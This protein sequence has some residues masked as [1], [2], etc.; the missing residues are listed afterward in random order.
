MTAAT[1]DWK[2]ISK[3]SKEKYSLYLCSREWGVLKEAVRERSGGICERCHCNPMQACHHL[4]YENKYEEK[5]EDLQAICQECHDFTHG[6]SDNDPAALSHPGKAF[7][8]YALEAM[9]AGFWPVPPA[10]AMRNLEEL[11]PVV[12]LVFSELTSL[13]RREHNDRHQIECMGEKVPSSLE[14]HW[15]EKRQSIEFIQRMCLRCDVIG[16]IEHGCPFVDW[17]EYAR[18]VHEELNVPVPRDVDGYWARKD[19]EGA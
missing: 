6:K 17:H 3:D 12:Q 2:S 15:D 16:Y 1:R 8:K 13:D 19:C 5:L 14:S 10:L 7:R 9:S 11:D 4:T 18:V